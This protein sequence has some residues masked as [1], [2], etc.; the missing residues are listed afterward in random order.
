MESFTEYT[1]VNAI[2]PSAEEQQ[3]QKEA[4]ATRIAMGRLCPFEPFVD[5]L[6]IRM[7]KP[8]EKL[9]K[10]SLLIVPDTAKD[11]PLT[12]IVLAVGP[13]DLNVADPPVEAKV[14]DRILFAKY[15]GSEIDWIDGE[16]YL[17]IKHSDVVA[18]VK[19]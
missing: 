15:A 2:A 16:T 3:R 12:G 10:S 11:A 6:V 4:E 9:T 13:F 14:G 8:G 1:D 19:E 18:R 7:E 5:R 17:F